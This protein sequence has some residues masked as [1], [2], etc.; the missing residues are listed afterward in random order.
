MESRDSLPNEAGQINYEKLYE[1]ENRPH[2]SLGINCENASP[3]IQNS[4][5]KENTFSG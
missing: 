5:I 4:L 3:L 2:V 1:K